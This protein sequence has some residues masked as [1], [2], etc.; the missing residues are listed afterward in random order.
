MKLKAYIAKLQKIAEK[1]PNAKVVYAADDEGNSFGEVNFTPT[2]GNYGDGDF[3][4][5]YC[6]DFKENFEINAVCI[7]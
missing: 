5:S 2:L 3:L 1:H 7:N 4:S 6:D